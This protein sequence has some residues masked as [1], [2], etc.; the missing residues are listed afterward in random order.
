MDLDYLPSCNFKVSSVLAELLRS[1][2]YKTFDQTGGQG[3]S[4]I[5]PKTVFA[6]EKGRGGGIIEVQH[7]AYDL[8]AILISN[9][10]DL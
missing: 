1:C 2:A 9:V 3:D 6:R 4:Y 5:T 8:S 7:Q 10:S